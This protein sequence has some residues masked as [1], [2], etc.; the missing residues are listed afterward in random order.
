MTW[1]AV[2]GAA[3]TVV[4]GYIANKKSKSSNKA[5]SNAAAAQDPYGPYR[6]D[7]AVRLNDLM[8]N[9]S[10]IEGTPEYKARQQAAARLMASQG[11]TG[12]GN[13]L[14]AAANAGGES[15]Q[16]AFNNLA[17]LSG[18]G[19]PA[20]AGAI[21]GAAI[22]SQNNQQA[23]QNW[24]DAANSLV[25]AGSKAYQNYKQGQSFNQ[26]IAGTVGSGSDVSQQVGADYAPNNVSFDV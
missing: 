16:Q 24:S 12:S 2:A 7:A 25:Y 14:V 11:Y 20:G 26:P 15:Y 21:Q 17:L 13:A 19:G 1:G 3:I 9:P 6:G 8:K 10:S 5:V 18:A 22:T 4:G 23:T